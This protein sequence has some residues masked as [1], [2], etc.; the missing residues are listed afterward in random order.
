MD[1]NPVLRELG[2]TEKDRV[3]IFHADDIG[4]CQAS[5]SSYKELVDVG[6]VSSASVMVPCSW[7]PDVADFCR[8]HR[9]ESGAE[10]VDTGIDMGVHLTL[11]SEWR[12]YRWGPISTRQQNSGMMDGMGYFH[13]TN[14]AAQEANP[15]AVLRE[16]RAQVEW[17]VAAG[18]DI[19][20][21]DS[22]MGSI[23]HAPFLPGYVGLVREFKVPVFL[24]RRDERMLREMGFG[25]ET[26]AL[27]AQQLRWLESQGYPLLDHIRGL[28]L[29]RSDVTPDELLA[30]LDE[31][32][33]GITYY[34][35][36][37]SK[38]TTE[39][40]A[41]APDWSA[42]VAH[43]RLFTDETVRRRVQE[44]G[45]HVIGYRTLQG[46]LHKCLAKS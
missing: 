1:S 25:Q 8:R 13:A 2:L 46:L 3:V 38:D 24:Q 27:F 19:T 36:H 43:H 6:L 28:P 26:A 35:I 44:S 31:L 14:A 42:R 7:A 16:I 33:P 23:F 22:H 29:N 4:M 21:I 9:P 41:I 5:V 30:E 45:V 32:P 18:I 20:H 11:T 17:A 34:I 15:T 40:R 12:T 37:P 39:L 10:G